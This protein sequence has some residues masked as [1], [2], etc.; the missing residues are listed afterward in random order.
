M[1]MWV[2][3]GFWGFVAGAALVIGAAIAWFF[4]LPQR[5]IAAITAFGAG[6]LISALSF[7]LM[8]DA[9]RRGGFD[10]TALGFL[11]G[12]LIDG[13]PESIVIG[14]SLLHGGAVSSV[15]VIAIFVSNRK[16]SPKSPSWEGRVGR[17]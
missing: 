6:V 7:E 8:D 11:G 3:A 16:R 13:I 1:P 4:R 17:A 14:L 2:M 5:S 15:A 12:A 10:S 9:Y